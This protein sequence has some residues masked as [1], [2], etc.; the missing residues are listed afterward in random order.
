MLAAMRASWKGVFG[1]IQRE[2]ESHRF[3]LKLIER[4][5]LQNPEYGFKSHLV[6]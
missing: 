4:D 5:Y 1:E 3:R 2:F 6:V